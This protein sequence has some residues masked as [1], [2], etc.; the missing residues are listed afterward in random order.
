MYC[1][2]IWAHELLR[3][4]WTRTLGRD[5]SEGLV[6]RQHKPQMAEA[7]HLE[8]LTGGGDGILHGMKTKHSHITNTN[9]LP[10]DCSSRPAL[11]EVEMVARSC[12]DGCRERTDN[13]DCH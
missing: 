2:A 11:A 12:S 13:N 4:S 1:L 10:E 9:N 5:V 6:Y 7:C 3:R 8:Q